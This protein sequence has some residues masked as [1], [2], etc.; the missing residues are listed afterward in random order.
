MSYRTCKNKKVDIKK[1]TLIELLVVIAIIAILSAILLPALNQAKTLARR[2]QC[3][4]NVRQIGLAT[5]A[6]AVDY[7]GYIPHREDGTI[8]PQTMFVGGAVPVNMNKTF[9]TPYVGNRNSTMFCPGR[10]LEVR[11][12]TLTAPNY[13]F[14]YVTYQL[15]W[16]PNPAGWVVSRPV[17][18]ANLYRASP[19]YGLWGCLTCKASSNYFGHD[20][21][22]IPKIPKGMNACFVDGAGRW[23]E[24]NRCQSYVN[25]GGT[26]YFWPIP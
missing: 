17:E 13:S 18:L 23:T 22:K 11:Y 4:N 19:Q 14:D 26:L 6:Y 3:L 16:L 25:R 12:P 10:L 2:I 9:I 20:E 8:S 1:F 24:W 7:N 15:F 5:H 21:P